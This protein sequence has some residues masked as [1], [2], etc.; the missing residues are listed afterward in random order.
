MFPRPGRYKAWGQFKR[1]GEVIVA[2]FVVEVA[3]PLLPRALTDLLIF[4]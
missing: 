4:D 1:G 3:A 2:D